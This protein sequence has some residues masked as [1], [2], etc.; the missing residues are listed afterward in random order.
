M[1][2][3]NP[4]ANANVPTH[5]SSFDMSTKRLY[6][7]KVGELL[8]V[9]WTIT[10]PND[11]LRLSVDSFTRTVPVNTAAYTRIKEYFDFYCVPL[12]YIHSNLNNSLM[13]VDD[14]A[15]IARNGASNQAILKSLPYTDTKSLNDML[16][17]LQ[18]NEQIDDAG[19]M[20]SY[21]S[22]KLLDILGYQSIQLNSS[23][24]FVAGTQTDLVKGYLGVDNVSGIVA[25]D[26][27][28]INSY[29]QN[30]VPLLAYQK[31]YYDYY[32]NSQW[33]TPKAYAYNV[34]YK[35]DDALITLVRDMCEMR[36]ANYPLD[37][38]QGVLPNSQYGKVAVLPSNDQNPSSVSYNKPARVLAYGSDGSGRQVQVAS[39]TNQVVTN[40]NVSSQSFLAI[41]TTLDALSIRATELMQRWR[42]VVQ[43][44]G[45]DFKQQVKAQFGATAPDYMGNHCTYIGG[46]DNVIT[47]NE[48]V[49]TNLDA[50]GSQANIAGKGTASQSGKTFS[51][52]CPAEHCVIMCIYHAVPLADYDFTGVAPQLLDVNISDLPQPAFD[53]LGMEPFKTAIVSG[54]YTES[55]KGYTIRYNA[56][57]SDYDRITTGFRSYGLYHAWAAPVTPSDL[58]ARAGSRNDIDYRS[59]KVK[60]QQLNSIFMPQVGKGGIH[61]DQLLVNSFVKC[62]KVTNLSRSGIPW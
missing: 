29:A 61:T 40:S 52:D 45:K 57:K 8:P 44:S 39:G 24:Q 2:L 13:Q 60:P 21:S 37:L 26:F 49:N 11:K 25:R 19:L 41:N 35:N 48:V 28:S 9:W 53:N 43:F 31:V 20:A 16:L 51:F 6:T 12:R 4:L 42:E 3:F 62:Y 46:I 47:I 50:D 30:L 23:G 34:D 10:L 58:Y 33:E 22:L 1:S 15:N 59:F 7:A 56:Y 14:I 5:R 38:I 36:Y 32:S 54:N 17:S 18:T 27:G 55:L